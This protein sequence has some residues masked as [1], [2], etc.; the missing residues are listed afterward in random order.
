MCVFDKINDNCICK[1]PGGW[2]DADFIMTG[3]QGCKDNT[4]MVHCPGMTDIE[5][6]TEFSLWSIMSSSLIVSTD[7]RNLT[8]IM[9][10]VKS[11]LCQADWSDL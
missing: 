2:N 11:F 5:Y 3:G 8:D 4:P 6:R 10:E 7:V 9:K 1:G